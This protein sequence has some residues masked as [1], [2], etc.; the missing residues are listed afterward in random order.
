MSIKLDFHNYSN[1]TFDL[2]KSLEIKKGPTGPWPFHVETWK[3]AHSPS[4]KLNSKSGYEYLQI[5]DKSYSSRFARQWTKGQI[6]WSAENFNFKIGV[7]VK[8]GGAAIGYNSDNEFYYF[9]GEG[10]PSNDDEWKEPSDK[11]KRF[12]L[13]HQANGHKYEASFSPTLKQGSVSVSVTITNK[14]K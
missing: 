2:N 7:Y 12:S 10:N 3:V 4:D 11:T 13:D 6:V 9:F 8:C 1:E 5:D 14:R